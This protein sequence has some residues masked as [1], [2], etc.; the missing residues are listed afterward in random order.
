MPLGRIPA[1]GLWLTS[2][3]LHRAVSNHRNSSGTA[4]S[5]LGT[6]PGAPVFPQ[7]DVLQHPAAPAHH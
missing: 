6:R 7:A 2:H 5:V 3:S 1:S 4:G